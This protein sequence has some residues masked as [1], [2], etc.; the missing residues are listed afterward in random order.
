MKVGLL[1]EAAHAQQAMAAET[2]T[3]LEA[4]VR[5]IDTIVREAVRQAVIDELQDLMQE[6]QRA[7]RALRGVSRA[8]NLRVVLWSVGITFLCTAVPLGTFF[9]LIPTQAELA[10]M[11]AKREVLAASV[12]RLEQRGGRVDLRRCGSDRLCV[13][14]DRK[15]PV[16]GAAGDYLIVKGY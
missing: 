4:H 5:E 15:A 12:A 3:H 1:V 16:Y 8:A 14:V 6:G 13:R 2:M 9:W 7:Q 11:R 10:A